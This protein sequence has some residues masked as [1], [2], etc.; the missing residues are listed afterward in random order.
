MLNGSRSTLYKLVRVLKGCIAVN[1][2][3]MTFYRSFTHNSSNFEKCLSF[4]FF[5][6]TAAFEIFL[7]SVNQ[8]AWSLGLVTMTVHA[9]WSLGAFSVSVTLPTPSYFVCPPT[10]FSHFFPLL[11]FPLILLVV[12][13]CF[14]LLVLI[15]WL[16]NVACCLRAMLLTLVLYLW[17]IF[18]CLLLMTLFHFISFQIHDIFS[19]LLR[20]FFYFSCPLISVV[21]DFKLFK[22][23]ISTS[24]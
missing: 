13:R 5:F 16:K 17:G 22:P 10:I 21:A 24:E 4:F 15:R 12:T 18:L 20:K 19:I 7:R 9:F 3:S 6:L 2:N 8:G 23:C 11:C 1:C 14:S